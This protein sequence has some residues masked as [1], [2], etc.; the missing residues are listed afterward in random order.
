MPGLGVIP[1]APAISNGRGL[2]RLL[3]SGKSQSLPGSRFP[4]AT[5]EWAE[6][7]RFLR[8]NLLFSEVG[9]KPQSLAVTS[10]APGEGKTTTAA[11]LAATIA[12]EGGVS[13]PCIL[14]QSPGRGRCRGALV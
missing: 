1:R 6:A 2:Q 13:G 4:A 7:F 8:T 10:M 11:N 14:K 5:P 3:P 9:V 12:R